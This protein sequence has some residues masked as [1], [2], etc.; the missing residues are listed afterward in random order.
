MK[1]NPRGQFVV[2]ADKELDTRQI[3]EGIWDVYIVKD[4]ITM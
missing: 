4:R 1:N 3:Y 2:I